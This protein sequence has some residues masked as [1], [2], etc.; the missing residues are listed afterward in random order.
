MLIGPWVTDS[1]AV[2]SNSNNAAGISQPE[3]TE[4]LADCGE[5]KDI[6]KTY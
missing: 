3:N 5:N 1:K 2:A 4:P 6:N